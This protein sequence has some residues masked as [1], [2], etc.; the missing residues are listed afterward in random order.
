MKGEY[1]RF[2]VDEKR[3]HHGV[4]L[5]EWLI[6]KANAM[7]IRGG[8][9]FRAIGGFGRHHDIHESRFFELAGSTGVEVEFIVDEAEA[10]QLLALIQQEGIR[11]FYARIPASFGVINPDAD[12]AATLAQDD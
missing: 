5:W 8:S 9:A 12:D 2:Y 4:L 3:R 1:L 11:V 6:E 10:R 7:G